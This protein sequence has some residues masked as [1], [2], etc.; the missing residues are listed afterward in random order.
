[1]SKWCLAI[2][3]ISDRQF[4]FSCGL[5]LI[6]F[7]A[8][9]YQ[10]SASAVSLCHAKHKKVANVATASFT[11]IFSFNCESV[12]AESEFKTSKYCLIRSASLIWYHVWSV[13]VSGELTPAVAGDNGNDDRLHSQFV[14]N[15]D[16]SSPLRPG[17]PGPGAGS[18]SDHDRSSDRSDDLSSRESSA[19]QVTRSF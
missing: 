18:E 17:G 19:E 1:M 14:Q 8:K 13:L 2:E 15:N 5:F 3:S 6:R 7:Q 12:H 9:F 11:R 10:K 16:A 4:P